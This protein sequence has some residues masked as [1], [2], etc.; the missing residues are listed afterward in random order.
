MSSEDAGRPPRTRR[1]YSGISSS[2]SG[3][4]WAIRR[5]P[6]IFSYT[7]RGPTYSRRL[8]PHPQALSLAHSRS[9]G[10]MA[11]ATCAF[12]TFSY[13]RGAPPP[14][15]LTRASRSLGPQAL[16]ARHRY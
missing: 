3:V 4:P 14:L 5:T 6:V 8:G 15:A 7:S 11:V 1:R 2:D 12:A 16:A 9:L 13:A 10:L